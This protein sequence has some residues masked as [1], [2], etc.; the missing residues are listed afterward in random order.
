MDQFRHGGQEFDHYLAALPEIDRTAL[1][2]WDNSARAWIRRADQV[3]REKQR[4]VEVA[5]SS[6]DL[7]VDMSSNTLSSVLDGWKCALQGME[8]LLRGQAQIIKD[9]SLALALSCWHLYPNLEIPDADRVEQRDPLF[10]PEAEAILGLQPSP[11]Q[12][13]RGVYWSLSLS[14]LRFYGAPE[15]TTQSFNMDTTRLTLEQFRFVALGCLAHTWTADMTSIDKVCRAI[16]R[17]Y[18][19]AFKG[20][21]VSLIMPWMSVL[22]HTAEEFLNAKNPRDRSYLM[23]LINLGR[24]K[25]KTLFSES[26]ENPSYLFGLT[27]AKQF[28]SCIEQR[29]DQILLLRRMAK[30]RF[31]G[32]SP[33]D[34]LI[35]YFETESITA[36]ATAPQVSTKTATA[37]D[38]LRASTSNEST[39]E[40]LVSITI[41]DES[42]HIASPDREPTTLANNQ[43]PSQNILQNAILS[44]N[45]LHYTTAI[46]DPGGHHHR[47]VED[48]LSLE[49]PTPAQNETGTKDFIH[50]V[51]QNTRRA[52]P[53]AY[54]AG[55]ISES[56]SP[57]NP[58]ES[59]EERPAGI[60]EYPGQEY[61]AA[62][63]TLQEDKD[64]PQ[65]SA[66][67]DEFECL[68]GDPTE[69]AMF[70][71]RSVLKAMSDKKRRSYW[72]SKTTVTQDFT[73][74]DVDLAFNQD[75]FGPR[76][77]AKALQTEVLTTGKNDKWYQSWRSLCA[78]F[79][80]DH[81]YRHFG[82]TTI[83]PNI[84]ER[85]L[86]AAQWFVDRRIIQKDSDLCPLSR[87]EA[88]GCIGYL[89]C[90]LDT[91]LCTFENVMA[92]S[93]GD[94]IFVSTT[95]IC[96]PLS[97]SQT[98]PVKRILG[99]VGKPGIVLLVPPPR[100][101]SLQPDPNSWQLVENEP[102]CGQ[103]E[104]RFTDTTLRLSFTGWTAPV[105]VSGMPTGRAFIEAHVVETLISVYSRSKWIADL[106][107]LTA[108]NKASKFPDYPT[109]L[110]KGCDHDEKGAR[111][112]VELT[113]INS[114]EGFFDNPPGPCVVMAYR[115]WL[116]R[117]AMVALAVP[118]GD[119]VV[120]SDGICWKCYEDLFELGGPELMRRALFIA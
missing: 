78:F 79:W 59:E 95:L 80:I 8:N 90:G 58:N 93:S 11:A 117:L 71:R 41:E 75:M 119:R 39:V 16:S 84:V 33:G 72:V 20:E 101:M 23:K 77:L 104:D 66:P 22:G 49:T 100:P 6:L 44:R 99:N 60:E 86:S 25:G 116:A 40:P 57:L 10:A 96:D 94:S 5:L 85:P 63:R 46:A 88:F 34:I 2:E 82:D 48:A 29:Y 15:R 37:A 113:S 36:R 13:T 35:Q 97:G 54:L 62:L 118:R 106:D 38:S 112:E 56:A 43:Q 91:E 83:D 3:M 103:F 65:S 89:E 28:L 73:P 69:I 14:K 32:A 110:Q 19:L 50:L 30:R 21:S 51:P 18:E 108:M 74:D 4:H 98:V 68:L 47:W 115:N 26:A 102:F 9:G 17:L 7:G 52:L 92:I 70:V 64:Y 55:Y 107:V 45:K 114:W 76:K 27:E 61:N 67:N 1:A 105:H 12:K 53:K 81:T 87:E 120:L 111:G 109:F 31:P 24:G 42:E